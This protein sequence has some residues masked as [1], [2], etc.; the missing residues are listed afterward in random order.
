MNY[1]NSWNRVIQNMQG[2]SEGDLKED[3]I[4]TIP[5][6]D[7]ETLFK[8]V[9]DGIATANDIFLIIRGRR[10]KN[11]YI[12]F[13]EVELIFRRLG[14]NFTEHRYCELLSASKLAHSKKAVG[15]TKL[16]FSYIEEGEFESILDYLENSVG[17]LTKQ[18]LSIAPRNL[19]KFSLLMVLLYIAIIYLS[20]GLLLFFYGGE[21]LGALLCA[22]IPVATMVVLS[23]IKVWSN[24]E[25]RSLREEFMKAFEAVTNSKAERLT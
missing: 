14:I 16:N 13:S 11:S 15:Y 5:R 4:M 12:A 6:E 21:I 23:R 25:P 18:N 9:D 20:Q 10:I 2:S 8:R 3:S 7:R 19:M 1:V 17:M 22:F 24:V